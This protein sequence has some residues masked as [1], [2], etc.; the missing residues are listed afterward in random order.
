MEYREE[1]GRKIFIKGLLEGKKVTLANVYLP[2]VGQV[3]FL[4]VT[5]E[6]LS[7]FAEGSIILGGD[8]NFVL[9]P[10]FDIFTQHSLLSLAAHNKIGNCLHE[11]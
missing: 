3:G 2:N 11:H 7:E 5:L 4:Q 10:E 8:F 9:N 6:K 1:E